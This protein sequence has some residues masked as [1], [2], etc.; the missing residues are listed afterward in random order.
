MKLRFIGD[1]GY[2][3]MTVGEKDRLHGSFLDGKEVECNGVETN[4]YF[5]T[6]IC[7]FVTPEELGKHGVYLGRETADP[8]GWAFLPRHVEIVE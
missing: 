7:Y 1:T 5:G 8:R 6:V 2:S 4:K 3:L